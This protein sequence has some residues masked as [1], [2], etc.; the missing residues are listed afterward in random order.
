MRSFHS[1]VAVALTAVA[2]AEPAAA[3]ALQD[4]VEKTII[5]SP[6]VRLRLHQYHQA[7]SEQDLGRASFLPTADASYGHGR[8][9][10]ETER[11]DTRGSGVW[12]WSLNLSQNLFNGYQSLYGDKR[13][14]HAQRAG[15]LRFLDASEQ[16]A[17][18]AARS[19]LDVLRYRR[20]VERAEANFTS[21][22][23]LHRQIE[24][25]TVAGVGRR[26]DL[27]QASGRL[28]LAEANLLTEKTNLHDVVARYTRVVG[29]APP[30]QM[31]PVPAFAD[32]LPSDVAGLLPLLAASPAPRAA[33]EMVHAARFGVDARRGAFMPTL[34]L[35][36]RQEWG[37]GQDRPGGRDKRSLVELVTSFNLSRGGADRARL[38]MARQELDM[39][40]DEQEKACRDTRQTL[41][42]AYNDARRQQENIAYL[43]QHA[44]STEKV[45]DAYRQQ[46]DIGQRSLLDLL[47]SENELFDSQRALVN[48]ESEL[49][50]ARLRVAA[51]GGTLLSQLKLKPAELADSGDDRPVCGGTVG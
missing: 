12:G 33:G 18:E 8:E 36:A 17:L 40:L 21:H 49:L 23:A 50:M 15:Y 4:A 29:E 46:F 7:Q 22:Q 38:K 9:T 11:G 6:E 47:D 26:V 10:R 2:L 19:Y 14:G 31:A 24:R 48:G 37:G 5:N 45:R 3:I 20:L 42:I 1:R 34:D 16:Q 44:L 32:A 30:P 41:H 35:R 28:A 39:A 51:A 13:L 27:E 25:K 43:R